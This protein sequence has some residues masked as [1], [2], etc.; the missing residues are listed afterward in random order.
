MTK[1]LIL[2]GGLLM[3][4]ASLCAQPKIIAHR[5]FWNT[6]GS[7]Q[8]SLTSLRK[9]ADLK[10]YGSEFDVW[11]TGDN[12]LIVNHDRKYKGVHMAKAKAAEITA[13]ELPNG[14][15]I[16]TLDAYLKGF[17][18]CPDLQLVLEMKSLKDDLREVKAVRKIVRKLRKY[19]LLDRTDIIAF[20]LNACKAFLKE[21]PDTKIY[22]LNG[23]LSPK[24]LK[25]MGFAGLDYSTKVLRE[26]P[27]WV[28]EAHDLGLE[29]NVWT[30]KT[31]EEACYF[32]QLGV[33]YLTTDFPADVEKWIAE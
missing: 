17:T 24:E 23:E 27:Q 7:A 1:K 11:Y 8:N 10:I 5:G 13:I 30:I 18:A 19:R 2:L 33:D 9:A 31:P 29:V 26:N 32:A 15:H 20:S 12:K 16:P 3:T 22:Y 14:E 25:E 6:D 28:K 4:V 21:L